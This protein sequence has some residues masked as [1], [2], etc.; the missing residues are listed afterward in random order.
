MGA[1]GSCPQCAAGRENLCGNMEHFGHSAGWK[2]MEYYPGGMSEVFTI[3]EE[4]AVP[5]P[6]SVSFEE[7]TFLD[8]LAVAVHSLHQGR[9][10]KGESLGIV[11][12][13]PIGMLAEKVGI[14]YSVNIRRQEMRRLVRQTAPNGALDVVIET[15][16]TPENLSLGLSLL[17]PQGRL[18][19]MAAGHGEIRFSATHISG[20]R[21]VLSSANNRYSEF[22][23]AVKLLA[24][25]SVKVKELIPHRFPLNEALQGFEVMLNK[26]ENKAYKVVILPPE[27]APR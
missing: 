14:P 23:R 2:D 21:E 26:Q 25:G 13:G 18:V 3:W 8:G 1:C 27:R 5:I 7:A 15:V 22:P 6:D 19:L 11:G 9:L 24:E 17:A 20:E 12:L 4:N 10:Q 16:G